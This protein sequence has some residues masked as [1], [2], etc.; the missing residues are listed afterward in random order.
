[1]KYYINKIYMKN[2]KCIKNETG[3]LVNFN[4][5]KGLIALSGPNGFGKTTIFDAIE[6]SFCDKIERIVPIN[7]GNK[8]VKD[9][10][11]IYKNRDSAIIA[12]ELINEEKNDVITIIK[13]IEKNGKNKEEDIKESINS[14][15][16]NEG[17]DLNKINNNNYGN[18]I[19]N[20]KDFLQKKL[21][22]NSE[23][24][25][26]FYYISQDNSSNFLKK[27]LLERKSI[28]DILMKIE[29]EIDLNKKI[30]DLLDS[31]K[32]NSI[33]K[34]IDLKRE[35]IKKDIKSLFN[36]ESKDSE[37][38]SNIIVFE[39][40]NNIEW[41]K[42]DYNIKNREPLV[43]LENL[44]NF[45]KNYNVFIA[46]KNNERIEKLLNE[47]L[48]MEISNVIVLS[49]YNINLD[50]ENNIKKRIEELD[51]KTNICNII[52]KISEF[53]FEDDK[54][55]NDLKFLNDSLKLELD[56]N[57][58][59]LD[60]KEIVLDNKQLDN[61][62]VKIKKLKDSIDKLNELFKASTDEIEQNMCPVC[63]TK[64]V[65]AEQLQDI[66]EN[67]I[68]E[69]QKLISLDNKEKEKK[70]K[71][72]LIKFMNC[73]Q[74]KLNITELEECMSDLDNELKLMRKYKNKQVLKD[75]INYYDS[76]NELEKIIRIVKSDN[77]NAITN[78]KKSLQSK[79]IKEIKEYSQEEYL[80]D[81]QIYDRYS[82]ILN[83]RSI[84]DD[85][86]DELLDR[87]KKK[88][89]YFERELS[90]IDSKEKVTINNKIK[91]L[92]KMEELKTRLEN[93]DK[94]YK[95]TIKTFKEDVV[96]TIEV[97][98]YIYTGKIIQTYQG[99]LGVF[100][101]EDKNTDNL[102]FTPNSN[103]S[104]H[105]IVNTFS[106]GQ[107]S[108]FTIAFLL[109]INQ[110]YLSRNKEVDILNTILIDDPVQTM[111]DVNIASL[112]EVL[113]NQ[114]DKYQMIVSTHEDEKI[115]YMRYK[116]EKF[117]IKTIEYNV[118]RHFFN[119]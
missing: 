15:W 76:I 56:L 116:F 101:K 108:A 110:L 46:R 5:D 89:R 79:F 43:E 30:K 74:E 27:S 17:I 78:L 8:K 81:T 49:D 7:K 12:I 25:N 35:E 100:I 4:L 20:L 84:F 98:L 18:K 39:G 3:V 45:I 50:Y 13:R 58:L 91:Q 117:G 28:F 41:D 65:S 55:I 77:T 32:N 19:D 26:Y 109:V 94:I 37:Y 104:Q 96:S 66:I 119:N 115:N 29:N 75:Y 99:G 47:N 70:V 54:V 72:H 102:V 52:K 113:R 106:S 105:D 6:L 92:I 80:L 64:F 97:P 22:I 103:E 86:I 95:E 40:N 90:L 44:I 36:V 24:F 34:L 114:F 68:S 2:F 82:L 107:L 21:G 59:I 11:L 16:I 63:K 38:Q 9:N 85:N 88:K 61:K 31:K 33:S 71:K 10:L 118:K 112:I 48:L 60:I 53:S 14:F 42:E 67:N 23:Y 62:K 111:D 87:A 73:C 83:K 51:S 93:L 57:R 1:M 69:L